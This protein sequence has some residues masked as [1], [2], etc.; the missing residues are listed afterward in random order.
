MNTGRPIGERIRSVCAALEQ[1]GPMGVIGLCEKINGVE[2]SNMGKY[3]SRA[4]G[5]G[6]LTVERGLRHR[7]NYSV[8]VVVEG[9]REIAQERRT[10]KQKP[11]QHRPVAPKGRWAGISSVFQIG[12]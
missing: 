5:L 7:A 1:Y 3:C 4:V 10:T 12:L 6:L 2:R 11:V 8:F 9:W